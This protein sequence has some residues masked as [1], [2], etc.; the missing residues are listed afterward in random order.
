MEEKKFTQ[1]ARNDW[2]AFQAAARTIA[3]TFG[4]TVECSPKYGYLRTTFNGTG[5]VQQTREQN[6]ALRTIEDL[7]ELVS[8]F[9]EGYLQTLDSPKTL[10][11]QQTS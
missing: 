6:Q 10:L 3:E 8:E 1:F 4:V 7:I 11:G 9:P 5:D 2:N